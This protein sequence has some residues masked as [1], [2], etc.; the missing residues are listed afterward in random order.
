MNNFGSICK[1]SGQSWHS[2]E[3]CLQPSC[4]TLVSE[5]FAREII[6]NVIESHQQIWI[7]QSCFKRFY[8]LNV[9]IPS[10]IVAFINFFGFFTPSSSSGERNEKITLGLTT[11]LAMAVILLQVA[12]QVP[13]TSISTPMIGLYAP[14]EVPKSSEI[15]FFTKFIITITF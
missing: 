11:L 8:I 13:R 15:I 9:I 12:E 2:I 1:V 6:V 4:L 5:I 14:F 10:L 3:W 7:I